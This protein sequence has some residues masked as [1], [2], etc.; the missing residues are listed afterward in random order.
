M[1]EHHRSGDRYRPGID[2]ELAEQLDRLTRDDAERVLETAIRLHTQRHSSETFTGEQIRHIAHELGLDDSVVDRAIRD[3]LSRAPETEERFWFIASRIRDR[4]EVSGSATEVRDR[5][6]AWMQNEEGLRPIA[7]A[8]DGVRWEK[9]SHWLTSTRLAFGSDATKAL[10]NM[11]EVVHRQ[12]PLASEEHVVEIDVDARRIGMTAWGVGGGVSALGVGGGVLAAALIPGGNDLMQFATVAVPSVT[13]A[14]TSAVMTARLWAESI[15]RGVDRALSGIA[16]P[17][18][19]SRAAR[20]RERRSRRAESKG[21]RSGFQGLVDEA[22][23]AIDDLF[24]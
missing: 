5:V 13:V 16:H 19:H 15:R 10:R 11:S 6:M 21:R 18:L 17:E 3:E 8:H 20:R 4:A 22:T 23:D 14:A 12:I 9:D 24:D 2:Q 7:R 1:Q